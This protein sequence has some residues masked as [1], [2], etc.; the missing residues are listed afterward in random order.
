[1]VHGSAGFLQPLG[2]AQLQHPLQSEPPGS[3]STELTDTVLWK[4]FLGVCKGGQC[5]RDGHLPLGQPL[6][7]PP[8][9]A[10]HGCGV[11]SGRAGPW[12]HWLVQ[13]TRQGEARQGTRLRTGEGLR[14]VAAQSHGGTSHG[15]P[16]PAPRL[17]TAGSELTRTK[18][19]PGDG[20]EAAE[21]LGFSQ[22]LSLSFLLTLAPWRAYAHHFSAVMCC[23]SEVIQRK[24]SP[25]I[26]RTSNPSVARQK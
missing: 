22:G 15:S 8:A 14:S 5:P 25:E 2:S 6:S 10:R 23:G 16:Q 1:M 12:T 7:P 11:H 20:D 21:L 4:V 9:I 24:P 18:L 19:D 13:S 17:L 26:K 3:V